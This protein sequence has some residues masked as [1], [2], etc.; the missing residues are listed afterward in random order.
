MAGSSHLTVDAT[1]L[2]AAF[3]RLWDVAVAAPAL[4]ERVYER[5]AFAGDID[6][7]EDRALVALDAA[8]HACGI[9]TH[10]HL[11]LAAGDISI[12]STPPPAVPGFAL[13]VDVDSG[14]QGPRGECPPGLSF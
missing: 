6:P 9:V 13:Y 10:Y 2:T 11:D 14:D 1:N 7:A 4:S 5:A 8:L 3:T 12:R